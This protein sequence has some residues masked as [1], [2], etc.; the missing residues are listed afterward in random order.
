M[1][2]MLYMVSMVSKYE[3]GSRY[4]HG[5]GHPMTPVARPEC[6]QYYLHLEDSR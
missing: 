2:H 1:L 5:Y 4:L 6:L 3:L